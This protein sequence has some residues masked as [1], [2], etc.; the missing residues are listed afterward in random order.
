MTRLRQRLAIDWPFI[1][2]VAAVMFFVILLH[3]GI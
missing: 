2:L 1:A 3:I